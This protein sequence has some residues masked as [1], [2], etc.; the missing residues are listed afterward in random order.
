MKTIQFDYQ[1]NLVLMADV[2]R[3]HVSSVSVILYINGID[4]DITKAFNDE[5]LRDFEQWFMMKLDEMN[6]TDE[7]ARI[8]F[9][10]DCDQDDKIGRD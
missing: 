6:E 3:D 9:L 5:K 4:H 7:E 2:I 10:I 8:D 1:D